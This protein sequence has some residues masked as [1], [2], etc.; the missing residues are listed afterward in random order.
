MWD[1]HRL[2]VHSRIHQDHYKRS[3]FRQM[4]CPLHGKVVRNVGPPDI[5]P[6][7]MSLITDDL[8]VIEQLGE[9]A[10]NKRR[11]TTRMRQF[12][13]GPQEDDRGPQEY[14]RAEHNHIVRCIFHITKHCSA[15][16]KRQQRSSKP[17]RSSPQ[18]HRPI[19][20]HTFQIRNFPA[21]SLWVIP[22]HRRTK[23]SLHPA[24]TGRFH[25]R[26]K[27]YASISD[28]PGCVQRDSR[29]AGGR[30]NGK[31]RLRHC[32]YW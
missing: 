27:C 20:H 23:A 11:G 13:R 7:D 29:P 16:H 21:D 22:G 2:T 15:E 14:G 31:T 26:F 6:P 32:L 3:Q 28:G 30:A 9:R 1:L 18:Q 4:R 19:R 8:V 25:N 24:R 12:N 5:G 10:R 17:S